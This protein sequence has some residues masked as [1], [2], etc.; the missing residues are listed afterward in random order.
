M[1]RYTIKDHP[2]EIDGR[3]ILVDIDFNATPLGG[4]WEEY[5]IED[6]AVFLSD[7]ETARLPIPLPAAIRHF[8]DRIERLLYE[9]TTPLLDFVASHGVDDQPSHTLED[10]LEQ[11]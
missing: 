5:E 2:V 10:P 9:D 11:I 7:A 8:E 6:V 1:T 4:I 3:S